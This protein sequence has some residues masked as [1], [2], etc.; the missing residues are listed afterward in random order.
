MTA[1]HRSQLAGYAAADEGR[2]PP[3]RRPPRARGH[4]G[5]ARARAAGRRARAADVWAG[6]RR[7]GTSR[8]AC[9]SR[10]NKS[11]A[12]PGR[13]LADGDEV[14]LIPPVSGR[15]VPALGASRSRSTTP[16]ARS[17]ATTPGRSRRSPA[18]TRARSR[19]REVVRLEYEAYEGMAEAEMERIATRAEGAALAIEVAIHHRV[20]VVEIGETSVVIAVSSP[21]RGRRARRLRGGDR[22]AQGDG[23]AVEEGD[24]RRRRGMDRAGLVSCDPCSDGPRGW[25]RP[26]PEHELGYSPI[27]R[28]TDPARPLRQI[29]APVAAAGFLPAQVRRRSCS[30]SRSSRSPGDASSPSAPTR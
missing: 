28:P 12:A 3:L 4:A 9:S 11:Y 17:L 20:G 16:C 5:S 10:V 15:R 8:R 18:P 29:W 13:A 19:G 7:S 30:S 14:A 25:S 27:K 23:A 24:L 26:A 2:R 6:A 22:H 21:H 1:T